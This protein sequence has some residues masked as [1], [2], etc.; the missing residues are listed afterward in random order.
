MVMDLNVAENI[1]IFKIADPIRPVS[2]LPSGDRF[3]P[4][5]GQRVFDVAA[6]RRLPHNASARNEAA[7][8][9]QSPAIAKAC[10]FKVALCHLAPGVSHTRKY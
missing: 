2:R 7:G 10:F 6:A 5:S 3:H 9:Y 4:L 8:A 1:W